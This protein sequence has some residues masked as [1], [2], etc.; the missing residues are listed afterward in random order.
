MAFRVLFY[1]NYITSFDLDRKEIIFYTN[2]T[3]INLN[4]KNE[5]KIS[6][7]IIYFI[8]TLLLIFTYV[9]AH[10]KKTQLMIY[11]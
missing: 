2:D 4:I 7:V 10:I 9:N 1:K 5:G 8:I 6:K 3:I 11:I